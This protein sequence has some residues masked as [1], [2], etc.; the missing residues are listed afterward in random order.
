[1]ALDREERLK[2]VRGKDDGNN[3]TVSHEAAQLGRAA[4]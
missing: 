2:Q 4:G 1:M 3:D